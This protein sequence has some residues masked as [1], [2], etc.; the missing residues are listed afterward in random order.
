[1]SISRRFKDWVW[2]GRISVICREAPR[3]SL[4]FLDLEVTTVR[5]EV[6]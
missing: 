5:F 2:R 3:G 4:Q 6:G 1:M